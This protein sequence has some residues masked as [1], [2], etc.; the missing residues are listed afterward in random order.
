MSGGTA[1]L[2]AGYYHRGEPR[3][4]RIPHGPDW[5]ERMAQALARMGV[6]PDRGSS[7]RDPHRSVGVRVPGPAQVVPA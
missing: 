1:D 2:K 6:H 4:L 5:P 3:D 7:D